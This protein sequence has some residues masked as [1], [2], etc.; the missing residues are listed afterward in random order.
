AELVAGA[1]SGDSEAFLSLIDRAQQNPL[2]HVDAT[3][4]YG[5]GLLWYTAANSHVEATRQLVDIGADVNRPDMIGWMPLHL[6]SYHGHLAVAQLLLERGAEVDAR[7]CAG[8]TPRWLAHSNARPGPSPSADQAA[9]E[10]LAQLLEEKGGSLGLP[11]KDWVNPRRRLQRR[12]VPPDEVRCCEEDGGR[13]TL[14]QLTQVYVHE[15]KLY[16]EEDC[17]DYFRKEMQRP[18]EEHEA[19]QL[20]QLRPLQ[21]GEG[22]YG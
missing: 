11:E 7:T 1:R 19:W 14:L 2:F 9:E 10:K 13:Y 4:R 8:Q 3:D 22:K 5:R 6:A 15:K 16:S 18:P 20:P 12:P 17:E 21:R